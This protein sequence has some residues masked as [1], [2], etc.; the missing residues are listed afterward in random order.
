MVQWLRLL[1]STA[2]GTGSISSWGA[3]ILHTAQHGKKRKKRMANSGTA[4]V[5]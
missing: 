4:Y 3:K 5:L 2:G 1:V